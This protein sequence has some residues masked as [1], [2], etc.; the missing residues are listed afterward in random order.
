VLNSTAKQHDLS[1][2]SKPSHR[3]IH[4]T[5]TA[6]VLTGKT[7]VSVDTSVSS[8]YELTRRHQ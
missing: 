2:Q 5:R 4:S 6:T 7:N 8:N 3:Y 1:T